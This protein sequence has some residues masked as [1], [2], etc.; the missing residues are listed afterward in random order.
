MKRQQAPM[1]KRENN[2]QQKDASLQIIHNWCYG[3]AVFWGILIVA[4]AVWFSYEDW[5]KTLRIGEEIG[6]SA[7][8]K[9]YS[10]RAWAAQHGGVYVPITEST[11]PNPYLAHLPERN[12]TTENGRELTLLNPAYM[13]RQVHEQEMKR[14]GLHSRITSQNPIRPENKPDPWEEKAL[15]QLGQGAEKIHGLV[16]MNGQPYLRV[17]APF[18]TKGPCLKCHAQQGYTVGDLRGGISV[19]V[20]MQMALDNFQKE[21]IRQLCFFLGA[22]LLGYIGLIA[23]Y[24]TVTAHFRKRR[25]AEERFATFF[26]SVNDAILVHPLQD[27]G[28]ARFVEVNP[29]ACSRYGY[30]RDEFFR[31]TALDIT[32]NVDAQRHS[33][34]GHRH[35]L[36]KARHLIF[37][38]THIK[39][40][41][42]EFPVEISASIV[43][44]ENGNPFVL[45]VVRDVSAR[46]QAEKELHYSE[47]R[48]RRL[49]ENAGDAIFMFDTRGK[50]EVVNS[51]ACKSLQYTEEE[52]Q[53][54][55]VVDVDVE[56]VEEAVVEFTSQ[57]SGVQWPITTTGT[58]QRKDGS[59]FPVEVRIDRM[60]TKQGLRFVAV[61]R[62]I[63]AQKQAEEELLHAHKMEAIGTLAGGIAHDFNNILSAILGYAEIA[64]SELPGNSQAAKDIDQ[65]I[66]AGQRA[67]ELVK[68]ILTFSR[69]A[70]QQKKPL[71]IDIIVKEVLKLLRSSLPSTIK[72]QTAIDRR[73]GMVLADPINIHQIVVN[74]C[75]NASHAIGNVHGKLEVTLRRVSLGPEQTA[76]RLD[77]KNGSYILLMVKDSGKGMDETTMARIFEPYFTTKKSQKGT[78]LGLAV[79]HGIVEDCHGFIEVQSTPGKGTTFQ[80]YLPA[81]KEEESVIADAE[82]NNP[83]PGGNERILLVD[84]EKAITEI[85]RSFLTS[86]GYHVVSEVESME[87]LLKFQASPEA[88]DLVITD[89]TMPELTGTELAMAMLELRPDLP[90]ILCTGYASAVNED[91]VSAIGI[92]GFAVKPLKRRALAAI[93]RRILDENK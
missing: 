25:Q 13:T 58:H 87:A 70:D 48:F 91:T 93:V 54:L 61:A 65:V 73:C 40:S 50:F 75:T 60:E 82:E 2:R 41:G 57:G 76:D 74:L 12:V 52:L 88:F 36:L 37:E 69:K 35:K 45:S 44:D 34:A 39:K 55:S 30:S 11:Q 49:V 5:Q 59:T 66:T 89:Q 86:L 14:Y 18:F 23:F 51:Q 64:K 29:I 20:P 84:D 19:S 90:I 26:S 47:N 21:F 79:V 3:A 31:L 46:K 32:K 80:V 8:E 1:T 77:I 53:Q 62:D 24:R 22:L 4:V 72:V 71:R 42:E 33:T 67:V 68:Q 43:D 17:M 6:L 28:F 63:T 38:S 92:Q 78:G 27:E 16:E 7:L 83:L 81:I 9:D 85:N 56:F 15:Q 10:Y